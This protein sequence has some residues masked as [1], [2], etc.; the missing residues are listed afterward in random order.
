M[1]FVVVD[2]DDGAGDDD[3]I[4]GK[5]SLLD[6]EYIY[7]HFAILAQFGIYFMKCL[8]LYCDFIKTLFFISF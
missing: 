6:M 7:H 4:K 5:Y 3:G 2:D 8:K 1:T